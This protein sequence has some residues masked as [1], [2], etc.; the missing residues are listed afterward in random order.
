MSLQVIQEKNKHLYSIFTPLQ[1]YTSQMFLTGWL[2]TI[3]SELLI[4]SLFLWWRKAS[5]QKI[6]RALVAIAM[7]NLFS[8]PV[9]WSFFPSLEPFQIL[10]GRYFGISSFIVSLLY[11]LIMYGRRKDSSKKIIFVSLLTFIGLN[12]TGGFIALWFGYG[13]RLPIAEGIP[14]RFTMPISEVFA[15][16]YEAWL[17]ATLSLGQLTLKQSGILSLITN[18]TSLIFGLILF[19]TSFLT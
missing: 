11:G 5:Q 9:V 6:L 14:Y 19:G 8:Y 4:A 3:S 12:I 18:A 10:L 17:I 13:N 15:V 7:V 2:L 16:V 1:E